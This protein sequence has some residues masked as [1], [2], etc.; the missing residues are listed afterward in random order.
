MAG[1]QLAPPA[2]DTETNRPVMP[3]PPPTRPSAVLQ[4]DLVRAVG[5]LMASLQ[6]VLH[7]DLR[8]SNILVSDEAE[9]KLA[10]F[11]TA[12]SSLSRDPSQV[13]RL[14]PCST[15]LTE[16][17]AKSEVGCLGLVHPAA[18]ARV[19]GRAG[20]A[21]GAT[22]GLFRDWGG[23]CWFPTDKWWLSLTYGAGSSAS[24]VTMS[25][26][27]S[28]AHL[29]RRYVPDGFGSSFGAKLGALA[30]IGTHV[31]AAGRVRAPH[32]LR[33]ALPQAIEFDSRPD[34]P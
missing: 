5:F 9:I 25:T 4:L 29:T 20:I 19:W 26:I 6:D 2:A 13:C 33:G 18:S 22:L 32:P 24:R 30:P 31:A 12:L 34:T 8:G 17:A 7:R 23:C 21:A 16:S 1:G 15:G 28:T 10:D 14:L 11:A 3:P 27:D